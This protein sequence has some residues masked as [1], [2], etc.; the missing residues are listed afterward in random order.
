[1]W[2][3]W[4]NKKAMS[5][6]EEIDSFDTSL[7]LPERVSSV[8]DMIHM[9]PTITN[10]VEECADILENAFKMDATVE[11]ACIL[12]WISPSTY[13]K[14]INQDATLKRRMELAKDWSKM[15][16]HAAIYNKMRKG[17]AKIALQFLK[18]RDKRYKDVTIWWAVEW[19][20][21][22]AP[23]V[24]FISVDTN[25]WQKSTTSPDEQTDTE[26]KLLSDWYV[27]ISENSVEKKTN[28]ENEEQVLRNI[29][30]WASNNE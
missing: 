7:K 29:D 15:I 27:N 8:E 17:D 16:A 26:Q 25:K 4:W 13:Y 30:L 28:W 2:K 20:D 24:Q 21:W 6:D 22:K 1:M 19:E 5:R 3:Y 11:E 23:I 12:A 18:L 14:R 10:E 9:S